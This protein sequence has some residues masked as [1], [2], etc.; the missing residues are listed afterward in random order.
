MIPVQPGDGGEKVYPV[1]L[2][3]NMIGDLQANVLH[4]IAEP[5][6]EQIEAPLVLGVRFIADAQHEGMT[7]VKI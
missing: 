2:G 6:A 3:R 1:L 7:P 5:S 4:V